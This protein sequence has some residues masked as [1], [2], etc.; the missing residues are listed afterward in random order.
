MWHAFMSACFGAQRSSLLIHTLCAHREREIYIYITFEGDK[1]TELWA[2][3]AFNQNE[4][5]FMLGGD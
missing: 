5:L 2:F 4:D 1:F 3:L